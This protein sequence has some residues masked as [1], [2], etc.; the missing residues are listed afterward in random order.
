MKLLFDI[1]ACITSFLLFVVLAAVDS[2]FDWFFFS[3]YGLTVF[4]VLALSA[5]LY[6]AW[7][8]H[9]RKEK[10]KKDIYPQNRL[11]K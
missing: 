8:I 7:Y 3:R 10:Q 1:M 5:A 6:I 11:R 2:V 9:S 4:V